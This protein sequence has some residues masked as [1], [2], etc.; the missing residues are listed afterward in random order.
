VKII[1]IIPVKVLTNTEYNSCRFESAPATNSIL[2]KQLTTMLE[3]KNQKTKTTACR[4]NGRSADF[5][6]GNFILGCP[7]KKEILMIIPAL[8]A[9]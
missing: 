6:S 4:E 2:I 1:T 3:I 8:I 7:T 5:T 9:M